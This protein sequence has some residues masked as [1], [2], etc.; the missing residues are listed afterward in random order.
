MT[1]LLKDINKIPV[2]TWRWLGV[3]EKNID[4]EFPEITPYHN[5]AFQNEGCEGLKAIDL[6][7][8]TM[9]LRFLENILISKGVSEK[10]FNIAD[11]E[12]NSGWY[13]EAECGKKIKEPLILNYIFDENN[14]VIVDNNIIVAQ[15]NSEINVVIL[16]KAKNIEAFHT[17][18]TRVFAKKGAVV[19]LTK[20]QLMDEKDVQIDSII[21]SVEDDG[22]VNNV[23]VEL[24]CR[25]SVT[26]CNIDLKGDRSFAGIYSV[27]L[28]DK[29]RDVDINYVITHKGRNSLSDIQTRGA[30]LD[31]SK[32]IFRGTLDFKKGSKGAKGGEEEYTV[33]LSPKVRNRSIPL[34]LCEEEDVEGQHAASSGK[35]DE[36]KLFYLMSRGLSELEAKKLIVEASF[37][38]ITERIP[39]EQIKGD[40]SEYI[41]RR[42]VNVK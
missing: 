22:K 11:S 7:K 36:N 23:L 35:I 16:Y 33:L 6:T 34:M 9:D 3:N 12:F 19:N 25:N 37:N 38:P 5:S 40:I 2:R 15:E 30:L 17:G 24:G 39:V 21:E 8:N 32:K 29:D 28:G 1:E 41:R 4:A 42:L 20:V 27:Y 26:N 14:K 13:F 18:I 31:E 10:L